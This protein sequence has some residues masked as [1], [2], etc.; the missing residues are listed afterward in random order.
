MKK[1]IEE[2]TSAG[3]TDIDDSPFLRANYFLEFRKVES[4]I[5]K[6]W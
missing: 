5:I 2:V 1:V 4:I 3:F 6:K